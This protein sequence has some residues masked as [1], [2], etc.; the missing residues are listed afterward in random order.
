MVEILYKIMIYEN[1][2]KKPYTIH[3]IHTFFEEDNNC[4]IIYTVTLNL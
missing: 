3:T 1:V 2:L 4:V